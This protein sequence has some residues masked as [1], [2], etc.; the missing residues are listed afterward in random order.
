[1]MKRAQLEQH[2]HN[3]NV[4]QFLDYIAQSE[5]TIKHGYQTA[6]GGG[7]IDN[8]SRHPG[9]R[10]AFKQMDGKSNV[11]TA[12]GRYQFLS[13]T[14]NNLANR[15]GFEDFGARNQDLGAIALLA[16]AGALGDVL[17]G[18][19][20]SAIRKSGKTWASLPSSPYAQPKRSMAEAERFFGTRLAPSEAP[21]ISPPQ[22]RMQSVSPP[23]A[24]NASDVGELYGF[25]KQSDSVNERHALSHIDD[26]YGINGEMGQYLN[27]AM[28]GGEPMAGNNA[29][30]DDYINRLIENV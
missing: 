21:Q 15:Y 17:N 4:R 1:M 29:W 16:D 3:P 25:A 19:W 24:I 11:T 8:L 13:S 7:L 12:A 30:I 27:E 10:H 5:G 14:W 20:A 2:L 22:V 28:G 26:I 18:D 23:E 6:F 9:K